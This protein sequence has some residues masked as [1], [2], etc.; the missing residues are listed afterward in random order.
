MVVSRCT[1]LFLEGGGKCGP[2]RG[3]MFSDRRFGICFRIVFQ[4]LEFGSLCSLSRRRALCTRSGMG[5]TLLGRI[6]WPVAFS[7]RESAK[8][9]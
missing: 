4:A 9:S 8:R 7:I 5:T 2:E 3:R 1:E 6:F